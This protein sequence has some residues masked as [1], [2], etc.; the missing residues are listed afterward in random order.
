MTKWITLNMKIKDF[1]SILEHFVGKTTTL[2]NEKKRHHFEMNGRFSARW[3]FENDN[4]KSL[5]LEEIRTSS[6]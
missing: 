4:F 3:K 1:Q 5:T 2:K 6:R